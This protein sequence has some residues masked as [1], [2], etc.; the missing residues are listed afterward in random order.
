MKTIAIIISL[1]FAINV[2][3]DS[4]VPIKKGEIS[5]VDGYV[6]SQDTEKQ[7]RQTVS[8]LEFKNKQLSQLGVLNE[9]Q[10]KLME[11]RSEVQAAHNKELSDQLKSS[12]SLLKST[13]YFL[14]GGLVATI[15]AYGASHAAR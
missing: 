4:L 9:Q 12:N 6:I 10:L 3:A 15:V 8:D 11:Q 2:S 5:P 13:G 1:L 7:M 14:L